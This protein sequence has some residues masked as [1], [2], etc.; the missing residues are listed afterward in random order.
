M[1]Q[2]MKHGIYEYCNRV[3]IVN[4]CFIE[5]V[6]TGKNKWHERKLGELI[7]GME[8]GNK[9]IFAEVSRIARSTLQVFKVLEVCMAK[10]IDVYIAKQWRNVKEATL[11]EIPVELSVQTRRIKCSHCGIKTE[12]LSWLEPYARITNR[13]RSYIKHI[14][15]VT[16][17]HW[18]TIKEIDKRRFQQVVPQVKWGEL[19]QLVMDEFARKLRPYLHG[20]TASASYPLNTCT[21]E[22]IDNK[23]KLIKR[24]GY[25]YRDTDYFFLKIKV[26]FPGKPR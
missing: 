9:L 18:H 2:T 20:I 17:V 8:V 23:I 26:A 15:Q 22:V 24:M 4:L 7:D 10:G 21:L 5:D 3:E 1:L 16:G 25:G 11:L 12:R 14:A 6:V 13:L 19:R